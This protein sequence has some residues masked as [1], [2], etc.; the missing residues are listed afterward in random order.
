[1]KVDLYYNVIQLFSYDFHGFFFIVCET[2]LILNMFLVGFV[3]VEALMI[4]R[5]DLHD[6]HGALNNWDRDSV[7]PCSWAMIT[8]S[9]EN[10]VIGL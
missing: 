10:F 3:S 2:F 9:P 6:P 4:M 8:C 7:D 1:M 5:D